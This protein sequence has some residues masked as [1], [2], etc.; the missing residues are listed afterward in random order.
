MLLAYVFKYWK[1]DELTGTGYVFQENENIV[2]YLFIS[3]IVALF[4][5]LTVSAEEIFKDRRILKRE[6][7]LHLSRHAYFTSKV[8]I[9]FT[10]S[11]LQTG[12]FA[13]I[14]NSILEVGS[15]GWQTWAVLFSTACFANMLGLNISQ[16]FNSA[17]TIYILIPIILI[18]QLVMGGLV[19]KFDQINPALRNGDAVP[20][21]GEVMAS[22]WAFEALSVAH[23]KDNP[24]QAPLYPYDRVLAQADYKRQYL[25]PV[26]EGKVEFCDLHQRSRDVKTIQQVDRELR[27]LCR[28]FSDEVGR[29]PRIKLEPPCGLSFANYSLAE[30]EKL[31][32]LIQ[33]LKERYADIYND[34]ARKRDLYVQAQMK[35]PAAAEAYVDR[36]RRLTNN[37]LGELVKN[38]RSQERIA[39]EGDRLVQKISPIYHVPE[40]PTSWYSFRTH[41]LAPQKHFGGHWYDTFY[42]NLAIIWAMSGVLYAMLYHGTFLRIIRAFEGLRRKN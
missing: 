19:I 9:L 42:F 15:M 12:L 31:H 11:A 38:T 29:H 21:Y 39:Q 14:G 41:F 23:F 8:I 36:A 13:W 25:L 10:L 18:P 35:T 24:H 7:F 1:V 37:G 2:V 4:L 32:A 27:I 34:A 20:L 5:G 30:G 26:L 6:S 33:A 22:R 28:T 16:A 40:R 3:V 17:V